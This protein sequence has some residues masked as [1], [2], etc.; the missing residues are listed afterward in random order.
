MARVLEVPM[1][2]TAEEVLE[3]IRAALPYMDGKQYEIALKALRE[4]LACPTCGGPM[5]S[6]CPRERGRAG[7]ATPS[8]AKLAALAEARKKRWP[9]RRRRKR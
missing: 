5:T 1:A 7:G 3:K 9:A 8:K 6:F 4:A 2:Q